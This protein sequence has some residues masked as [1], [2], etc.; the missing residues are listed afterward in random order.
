MRESRAARVTRRIESGE[1]VAKSISWEP[2]RPVQ[3]RSGRALMAVLRAIG[4]RRMAHMT[5]EQL[6]RA[7]QDQAALRDALVEAAPHNE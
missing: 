2:G 5:P 4:R 3:S 7:R 6:D 1:V